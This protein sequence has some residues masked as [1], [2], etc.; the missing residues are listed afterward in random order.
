MFKQLTADLSLDLDNKWS[1]MKTHG[2]EDWSSYPSYLNEVIPHFL[3]VLEE[4]DLKIT[5]FI[6]G[7][8]AAIK[9]NQ[10]ALRL[11]PQAGHEIA[12]HSFKH[13]PWLQRYTREQIVDELA[14]TEDVLRE[15]SDQK[16]IGFR[17][18]GYSLSDDVLEV[19]CERGY[20][21]DASTLPTYLGPM[22]RTYY[23]FKSSFSA[24]ETEDRANLFGS[25]ADGFRP[26]KPYKWTTAKGEIIEMPVSTIPVFRAPFHFSYLFFLAKY[27]E[28]LATMYFRFAVLMCKLTR[29]S[30]S[31]LMHPL[32]FLGGDEVEELRFFPGM[33]LDGEFKRRFCSKILGIYKR[34]FNVLPMG[35]R[36][37]EIKQRESQLSVKSYPKPVIT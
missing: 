13:E 19:L 7:Q 6:V 25:F 29:T 33:S 3:R 16:L 30:P 9:S 4:H 18:P 32:D 5:V 26:L 36:A 31:L 14:R 17:G 21:F 11:I 28:L 10:D 35:K 37:A 24:E 34:N 22:A 20:Q 12:N 15:I 27:S 8:D 1:Y 2:D 23:F